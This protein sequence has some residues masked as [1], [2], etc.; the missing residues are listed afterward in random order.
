MCYSHLEQSSTPH[1][2][3]QLKMMSSSILEAWE[4]GQMDE[5]EYH[6]DISTFSHYVVMI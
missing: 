5:V 1:N 4:N 3:T 2:T 6:R